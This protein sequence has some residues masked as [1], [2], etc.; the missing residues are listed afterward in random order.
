MLL[1]AGVLLCVVREETHNAEM[2]DTPGRGERPLFGTLSSNP[3][4]PLTPILLHPVKPLYLGGG[5]GVGLKPPGYFKS[6]AAR[7]KHLVGAEWTL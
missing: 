3:P 6:A 5:S 4:S 7:N 2:T 1:C